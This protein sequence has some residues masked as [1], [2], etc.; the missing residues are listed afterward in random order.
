ME[1]ELFSFMEGDLVK[2]YCDNRCYIV[3]QNYFSCST[4]CF[5]SI[6]SIENGLISFTYPQNLEKLG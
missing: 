5:I 2:F 4:K 1:L 3:T 6:R